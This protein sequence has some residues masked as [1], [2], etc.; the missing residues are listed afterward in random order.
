MKTPVI[1]AAILAMLMTGYGEDSGAQR[2]QKPRN[3]TEVDERNWELQRN[4]SETELW[5]NGDYWHDEGRW[6]RRWNSTKKL[7]K[8]VD[9]ESVG[10]E[11]RKRGIKSRIV[12]LDPPLPKTTRP[13]RV[14]VEFFSRV[15]NNAGEVDSWARM[16][17]YVIPW[18]ATIDGDVDLTMQLVGKGPGLLREYN[19]VN[20]LYQ[21]MVYGWGEPGIASRDKAFDV[22]LAMLGARHD[23]GM[24]VHDRVFAERLIAGKGFSVEEWNRRVQLDETQERI[25]DVNDRY[26]TVMERGAKVNRK[27]LMLPRDPVILIDGEYLFTTPVSGKGQ[28]MLRMANWL[29]AEQIEKMEAE[30]MTV[31]YGVPKVIDGDE[32]KFGE[33]VIRLFGIRVPEN[34]WCMKNGL[35]R[36][37]EDGH[38]ELQQLIRRNKIACQWTKGERLWAGQRLAKCERRR[39]RD[40]RCKDDAKCDLGHIL[41]RQGK[42]I[43]ISKYNMQEG[44]YS[45]TLERAELAAKRERIGIWKRKVEIPVW[46][47]NY[48]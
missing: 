22:Y 42:A 11:R 30:K 25:Q 45:E 48:R 46:M 19:N 28:D 35:G 10:W 26:R 20:K 5:T 18:F 24:I 7:W 27:V 38:R 32:L 29:I 23:L 16:N 6:E 4:A 1:A 8:G 2:I 34:E 40:T 15:M 41:V 21:E 14:Q 17:W 3:M 36:C 31:I 12:I 47:W 43:V 37:G 9:K 39:T 44:S 13:D 33:E